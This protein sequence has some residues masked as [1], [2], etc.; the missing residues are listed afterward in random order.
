VTTTP[1]ARF[2]RISAAQA[3][4]LV[5]RHR[6]RV[7]PELALYDVRDRKSFDRGHIEG[8]EHLQD[9]R[10]GLVLKFL[11]KRTTVILYCYHGHASQTFAATFA[12]FRF[13]EVYS[14][15]GGY[16]PFATALA[17]RERHRTGWIADAEPSHALVS[18]LEEHGFDRS[19]L[20]SPRA[21][22]MTALMQA[23]MEGRADLVDELV[24]MGADV[25]LRNAQGNSALWM[26]CVSNNASVVRHLVEAGIGVDSRNDTGAT[27]LMFAASTG[28]AHL[29]KGLLQAGANPSLR[30]QEDRR[31]VDLASTWECVALLR[32]RSPEAGESNRIAGSAAPIHDRVRHAQKGGFELAPQLDVP[33]HLLERTT[34]A[35][36]P[37]VALGDSDREREVPRTQ[38]WRT[39]PGAVALGSAQPLDE[40]EPKD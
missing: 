4:E 24:R 10:L 25:R 1:V 17:R 20:D 9:E 39:T 18:F 34:H 33:H 16:E 6:L 36:H 19:R 38:P 26:A 3:A 40:V 29:V 15:D 7:L 14:V 23:A 22:G 12:D 8:A 30:N 35:Q 31:A 28:R 2:R 27:A 37:S 5:V 11:P 13:A 21:H 32:A